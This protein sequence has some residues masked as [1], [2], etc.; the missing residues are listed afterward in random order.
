[1]YSEEKE[2]LSSPS[3]E[4]RTSILENEKVPLLVCKLCNGFPVDAMSVL[5]CDHSYYIKKSDSCPTLGNILG[6]INLEACFKK[7]NLISGNFLC[8]LQQPSSSGQR[9]ATDKV[10]LLTSTS[11][12]VSP[13]ICTSNEP[14]SIGFEFPIPKGYLKNNSAAANANDVT[15][16]SMLRTSEGMVRSATCF[17]TTYAKGTIGTL[18]KVLMDKYAVKPPSNIQIAY[19]GEILREDYSLF[20]VIQNF[21]GGAK[22]YLHFYFQAVTPRNILKSMPHLEP[23][24]I[25]DE[26]NLPVVAAKVRRIDE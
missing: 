13:Q 21:L 17:F 19:G 23:E 11:S 25:L 24:T 3:Q 7:R 15:V 20:D 6:R 26:N 18:K 10:L 8:F 9:I 16:A 2:Q 22:R 1:M 5:N 4:G 14:I 12:E